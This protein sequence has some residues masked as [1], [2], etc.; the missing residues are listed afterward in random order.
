M[1]ACTYRHKDMLDADFPRLRSSQ[2]N[3]WIHVSDY[4]AAS[5]AQ[6][7]FHKTIHI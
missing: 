6:I 1:Y 3:K 4:N 2:N 5:F 7:N